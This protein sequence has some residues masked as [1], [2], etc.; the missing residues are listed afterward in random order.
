MFEFEPDRVYLTESGYRQLEAELKR[1][2]TVER[3]RIANEFRAY[4]EHGEFSSEDT[5][6]ESLKSEL[7]FVEARILE[8]RNVLQNAI[9]VREADIPTD[10][11][12]VGSFVTVEEV[13]T[14]TRKQ[15]RIVGAMEA[16]PEH[17]KLSYQAPVARALIGHQEGDEVEVVLP[18]GTVRYRIMKIEK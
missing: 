15:F 14:H 6:L 7:A 9:I 5:E 13:D 16:D 18:K 11:V 2:Q 17:Q 8:L 12:G 10:R 3:A 4:K 1:L